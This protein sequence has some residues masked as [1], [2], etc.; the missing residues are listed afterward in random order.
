MVA[1]GNLW[2]F[3]DITA[4]TQNTWIYLMS[5][6]VTLLCSGFAAFWKTEDS[7]VKEKGSFCKLICNYTEDSRK[8]QMIITYYCF[9]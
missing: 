5:W 6:Y 9:L 4:S 8:C 3:W 1:P 7:M 2:K